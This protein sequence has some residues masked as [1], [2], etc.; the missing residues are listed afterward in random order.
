[1]K[2]SYFLFSFCVLACLFSLPS[3]AQT[4]D[5]ETEPKSSYEIEYKKPWRTYSG[6]FRAEE[7]LADENYMDA[8][9]YLDELIEKNKFI[10][11]AYAYR[12]FAYLELGKLE[13]AYENIRYAL[14]INARHMGAY[15]YLGRYH[16][17]GDKIKLARE[18]LSAL[19]QLCGGKDCP[20]YQDLKFRIRKAE[21]SE[22][23]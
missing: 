9:L 17:M 13:Q 14:N 16:L 8:V 12:A 15:N 4:E 1:M 22:N 21:L 3:Y 10:A 18:Q 23:D 6:L 11:D 20:E 19:R 7:L 2:K 5:T